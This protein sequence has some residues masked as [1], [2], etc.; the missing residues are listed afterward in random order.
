MQP[1]P[2][3]AILA[4]DA[5]QA[6]RCN[7]WSGE[8]RLLAYSAGNFGK[9]LVFSGADLTF[10]FILTDLLLLSAGKAGML[11]LAALAGDLVFDLAAAKLV[12][13]MHRRGR[14]Y[15]WLLAV[16]AIPAG[17]AFA[18]IYSLPWL[19]VLQIGILAMCLMIFRSAYAVIDVP[20]NALMAQVTLDSRSRGRVSGYRRFFST[21]ASLC[22]AMILTPMV[23][24][25]AQ[26]RAFGP[27]SAMGIAAGAVF[28]AVMIGCALLSRPLRLGEADPD[29]AHRDGIGVPLTDPVLMAMALIGILTGFAV[30]AFERMLLY[31][32]TYVFEMPERVPALLM[33]LSAGQFAGVFLWTGL[34]R[35]IGSPRLLALGHAVCAASLLLLWA[36]LGSVP[37]ML[38]SV[39]LLGAGQTC[40]FM[41]PWGILADAID[42]IEW[43]HMRRFETG[44]FAFFLVIVKASGAASSAVIGLV[45]GGAGYIPQVTQNEGARAAILGLG[46]WLPLAGSLLAML[47]VSRLRIDHRQHA[48]VLAALGR[49]SASGRACSS[50]GLMRFKGTVTLPEQSRS[51]D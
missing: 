28:S 43:R 13:A 18:L 27:L 46:L 37:A 11:M 17:A 9:N 50:P 32:G 7:R 24:E 19:G 34:T 29:P 10:L 5:A 33:A 21:A 41:L 12:I 3:A 36:A 1:A 22:L 42:I 14:S 51:R 4:E 2:C 20:H 39:A 44:I 6:T 47:V 31:L 38:A 49:R 23:Q 35:W 40:V 15:R 26:S 30:P 16:G 48:R 8:L 45:L 25:A